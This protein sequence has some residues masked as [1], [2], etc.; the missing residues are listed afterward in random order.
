VP[1]ALA[2]LRE[3]VVVDFAAAV[4]AR[5]PERA[6]ERELDALDRERVRAPLL[7]AASAGLRSRAGTSSRTT[8]LASCGISFC[9]KVA[10]RSS[11]R[12]NSRASLA[13][14]LSYRELAS[15]SIAR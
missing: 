10:I 13:V 4:R 8:C 9:R 5:P 2:V 6:V 14:S 3:R 7:A 1:R 11:W 12:R 15:S